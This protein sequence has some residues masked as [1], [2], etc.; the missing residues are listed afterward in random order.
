MALRCFRFSL[1]SI[2]SPHERKPPRKLSALQSIVGS[3]WE[4]NSELSGVRTKF[5]CRRG[6]VPI[7]KQIAEPVVRFLRGLLYDGELSGDEVWSLGNWLNKQDRRILEEWPANKLV[8]LLQGVF[9]DGEVTIEE[10]QEVARTLVLIEDKWTSTYA[11]C[12]DPLPARDQKT[13][14]L[15]DFRGRPLLP[16]V[17]LLQTVESMSGNGQYSVDLRQ[18]TCTCGD[19]VSKRRQAPL[20]DYKRVCKHVASLFHQH[21]VGN[22]INDSLFTAFIVD[23]ASRE[24]GTHPSDSW[25]LDSFD[26]QQVLYG[27]SDESPWINVFAPQGGNVERFGFNRI[28]R[29]WSY[30]ESPRGFANFIRQRFER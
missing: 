15:Q 19:W 21:D 3:F 6:D 18:H 25:F 11:E 7:N 27:C 16:V 8:P 17:D 26:S 23:H 2:Q 29:R 14:T 13:Y 4:W 30:G 28:D 10:M 24:R 12:E 20:Q 1:A 5:Q 9:A 22:Q